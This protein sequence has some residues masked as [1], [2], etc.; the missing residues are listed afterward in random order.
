MD[1]FILDQIKKHG[2]D[3]TPKQLA[4]LEMTA[5]LNKQIEMGCTDMDAI[6]NIASQLTDRNR[7]KQIKKN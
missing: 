7:I 2:N 3:T 5:E 6:I 4:Q 1:Q